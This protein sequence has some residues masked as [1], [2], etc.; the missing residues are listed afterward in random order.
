MQDLTTPEQYE[1]ERRL[2]KVVIIEI[3]RGWGQRVGET[4]EFAT[5]EEAEAFV[6]KFNKRNTALTAPDWYMKADIVRHKPHEG[7]RS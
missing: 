5:R 3:E 1:A 7:N 6:A 4:R 2:V